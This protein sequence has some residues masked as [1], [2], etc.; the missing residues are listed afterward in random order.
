[1]GTWQAQSHA[2]SSLFSSAHSFENRWGWFRQACDQRLPLNGSHGERGGRLRP[3]LLYTRRRVPPMQCQV[4]RGDI[5]PQSNLTA[6]ESAYTI[7]E[8]RAPH[9]LSRSHFDRLRHQIPTKVFRTVSVPAAGCDNGELEERIVAHLAAD[10]P[11]PAHIYLPPTHHTR[12]GAAVLIGP[13]AGR[14]RASW[15]SR[16]HLAPLTDREPRSLHT[17]RGRHPVL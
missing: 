10:W 17:L 6:R 5:A 8:G 12:A 2:C 13:R 9:P 1:M 15:I 3:S 14:W 7:P 16:L 11:S 4:S